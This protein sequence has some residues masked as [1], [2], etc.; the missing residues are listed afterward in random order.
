[1]VMKI[2]CTA[3][4]SSKF[5]FTIDEKCPEGEHGARCASCHKQL[6]SEDVLP[7][8]AIDPKTLALINQKRA[9]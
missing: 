7:Q 1:M 8:T 6:C 2:R 3:C 5:Y 9:E 4:G